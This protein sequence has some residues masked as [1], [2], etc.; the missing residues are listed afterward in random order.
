MNGKRRWRT[1]LEERENLEIY[2]AK[3]KIEEDLYSN[4]SGSMTL[5]RCRTNTIKLNWRKRFQ[6]GVV[7]CPVCVSGAE[8]ALRHFLKDC[9]WLGGISE[10][11]GIREA[12]SADGVEELLLFAGLEKVPISPWLVTPLHICGVILT[13]QSAI[14]SE[15]PHRFLQKF[16]SSADV[17]TPMSLHRAP[18]PHRA[19]ISSHWM[20]S[21]QVF[22]D[23][24]QCFKSVL[25]CFM[26]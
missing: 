13:L 25:W 24:S 15:T 12:E 18:S 8:E 17:I 9:R 5:F 7:D 4:D 14:S 21:V 20:V 3:N 1:E 23:V 11:H 10:I 2:R 26:F 16:R 22:C 19:P 6:G